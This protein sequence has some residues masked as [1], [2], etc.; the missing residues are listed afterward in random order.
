[1]DVGF[2]RVFEQVAAEVLGKGAPL[3]VLAL[4]AAAVLAVAFRKRRDVDVREMNERIRSLEERVGT[5]E[6]DLT[7][8]RDTL[9]DRDRVVFLLRS[10][11]ARN[12]LADP[13]TTLESA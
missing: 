7:E 6:T 1:M 12:G 3:L 11:L 13:T 8:A 2:W 5:L 4:A 10:T 9:V